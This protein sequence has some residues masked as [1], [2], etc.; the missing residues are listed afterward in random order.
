MKRAAIYY[1]VSTTE[2]KDSGYSLRDQKAKLEKYCKDN[3]I[4]IVGSYEEDY[5]AKD[6]NR[7]AYKRAKQFCL[8][9]QNKVNL[10]LVV[11]W[12]RF[13]RN[14]GS[15]Y[16]EINTLAKANI[17]VNAI[18]QELDPRV[19]ENLLLQAIYLA[20][21][22]IENK[23][24]SLNTTNGM[25]QAK[26][27]GR[28]VSTAPMGYTYDRINFI[29]PTLVPNK[30]ADLLRGLFKDYAK[31]CYT[32]DEVRLKYNRLGLQIGK[33]HIDRILKNP[34]YIGKIRLE[35][36]QEEPEEIL[37]G[38]HEAIVDDSIFNQVQKIRL[39]NKRNIRITKE[40]T[41]NALYPLRG[42]LIC[43]NCGRNITASGA[44]SKSGK[45][46]YY[47]HC[48]RKSGCK[49]RYKLD[50]THKLFE[51]FLNQIIPNPAVIHLFKAI[52]VDVFNKEQKGRKD[53]AKLIDEKINKAQL[54]LDT[55]E[56]KYINDKLDQSTY[57][58]WKQKYQGDI[59]QL[60]VNKVD[61]GM[62]RTEFDRYLDYSLCFLTKIKKH[63]INAPIELKRKILGLIFPDKLI[64]DGKK[65][66]TPQQNRVL[67]LITMKTNTL[68]RSVKQKRE[69]LESHSLMVAR[70][71]IEPLLPG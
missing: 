27:E 46:H 13:S 66:Q 29:K 25:R 60:L 14:I 41:S 39:Q 45:I 48:Q 18:E 22:E 35:A 24:R 10:L 43:P 6:F 33:S 61:Y 65:Y 70:R 64:F 54:S 9:K 52:C 21:P 2:Q 31:G 71:G 36:W 53:I 4:T 34:V 56:E 5:S 58:K 12:D 17:K 57:Q 40:K 23:R 30:K 55:L 69:Q 49:T 67:E 7:P 47:Y 26:R 1:R 63:F 44:K 62:K 68:Q 11:K 8:N 37:N 59:D 38:T 28:W 3:Q 32:K 51:G 42:S 50:E 20:T 19:P 15:S 16:H